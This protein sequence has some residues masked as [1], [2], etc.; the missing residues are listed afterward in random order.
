MR[1]ERL[2][3][4]R[5][6]SKDFGGLRALD[7]VSLGAEE[8]KITAVIGPNGAGKTTLINAISRVFKC[9]GGEILFDNKQ[10]GKLQAHDITGVGIARTFQV[11]RL[12]KQLTVLEN[13][14]IGSHSRMKTGIFQVLCRT[15][16]ARSEE[17]N[18][19]KDG[20]DALR[21]VGLEDKAGNLAGTLAYGQQR[22]VEL[23]RALASKPRLLLLDEP[24]AGLNPREV[25]MLFNLFERIREQRIT[26]VLVEHNMGLVMSCAD[27][28]VV[29]AQGRTIAEGSPKEI[30]NNPT[31]IKAY[32]GKGWVYDRS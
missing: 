4:I 5:E 1:E 15:G 21:F 24:A 31:V 16:L 19:Q 9:D 32:L 30:G 27:M 29:L 2:L 23:A 26:I 17:E 20:M 10:I 8:G 12:F 22:L 7:R 3:S 11:V 18:A 6:L 13:V 25:D 14:M 28:V